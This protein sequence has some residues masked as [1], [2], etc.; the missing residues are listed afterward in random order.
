MVKCFLGCFKSMRIFKSL[1]IC[2]MIKMIRRL[3]PSPNV[4]GLLYSTLPDHGFDTVYFFHCIVL[5]NIL[6]EYATALRSA[7]PG[8]SLR[9]IVF[10]KGL[11]VIYY[12]R[13][14]RECQSFFSQNSS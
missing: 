5:H 14:R 12:L 8:N 4:H 1:L 3:E 10:A 2:H 7:F 6:T 11:A 13:R 9:H